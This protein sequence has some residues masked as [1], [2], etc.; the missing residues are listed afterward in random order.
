MSFLN[1]AR[2]EEREQGFTLIELLVVILIIGILSAIAIPAYLNQRKEAADSTL[3]F[4]M[5]N[6]ATAY[7]LWRVKPENKNMKFREIISDRSS[8]FANGPGAPMGSSNPQTWNDVDEFP[9]AYV[10]PGNLVEVVVIT[11]PTASWPRAHEEGEF[12]MTGYGEGS[13]YDRQPNTGSS[14]TEANKTL[15]YD[16]MLGGVKDMDSLVQAQ[17][18]GEES[19]CYSYATRFMDAVAP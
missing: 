17:A 4:D 9:E 13:H 5:R 19:A 14:W 3:K 1:L 18:N 8:I 16:S 10:S 12:C 11:K 2:K 7:N 6:V 15:Y